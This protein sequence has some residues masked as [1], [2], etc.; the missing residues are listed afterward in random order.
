M[1]RG[2]IFLALFFACLVAL[3]A[4]IRFPSLREPT[5]RDEATYAVIGHE[6]NRG[7]GLYTDLWDNKPPLTFWTYAAAERLVEYGPKQIYLLGLAGAAITLIPIWSAASRWGSRAAIWACLF[8]ACLSC[9]VGMDAN[10]ANTESFM[11][12]LLAFGFALWLGLDSSKSAWGRSV[13][14][15][16]FIALASIFKQVAVLIAFGLSMGYL[17]SAIRNKNFGRACVQVLTIAVVGAAAWGLLFAYARAI[18]GFDDYWGANI[19]FSKAY[20]SKSHYSLGA[21][22]RMHLFFPAWN[23]HLGPLYLLAFAPFVV[24]KPAEGNGRSNRPL[25]LGYFLGAEWAVHSTGLFFP[26]YYQLLLP[27]LCV[28]GGWGVDSLSRRFGVKQANIVASVV[29]VVAALG[30]GRILVKEPTEYAQAKDPH[31]L[32]STKFAAKLAGLLE[33]GETF[34]HFGIDANLYLLLK[35]SPPAGVIWNFPL[36]EGPLQ[37]TLSPRVLS[38]LEAKPPDYCIVMRKL[39]PGPPPGEVLNWIQSNYQKLPEYSF[40]LSPTG[41]YEYDVYRRTSKP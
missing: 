35:Q 4:G 38:Q 34:Y 14:I 28:C 16:L 36:I 37:K 39:E 26:H 30:V 20:A 40:E 18:G 11:N 41:A 7:R 6:I 9:D 21:D 19:V 32:G 27:P 5:H 15:G 12:P 10:Q 22:L 17:C 33:P 8:W 2:R 24:G 13:L 3:M 31:T 29:L 23:Y 1:T 25:A